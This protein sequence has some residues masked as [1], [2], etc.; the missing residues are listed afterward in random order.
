M[1][2]QA[3]A[4]YEKMWTTERDEYYL[5]ETSRS[6]RDAFVAMIVKRDRGALVIDDDD[7]VFIEIVARMRD[8]GVELVTREED[9]HR[10]K[11]LHGIWDDEASES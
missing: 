9:F 1:N 6:T 5:V 10:Q 4:K 7:D 11:A 8:A 3:R 2:E